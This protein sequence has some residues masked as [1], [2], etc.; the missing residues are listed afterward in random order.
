MASY[1]IKHKGTHT[2][3][4]NIKTNYRSKYARYTSL[5]SEARNILLNTNGTFFSMLYKKA[6]GSIRLMNARL[7]VT[8]YLMGNKPVQDNRGSLVTIYETNKGYRSIYPD[9]IIK[10]NCNGRIFDFNQGEIVL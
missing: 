3:I 7:G 8:R 10:L 4:I 9:Q 1:S 5:D 6:D 2:M